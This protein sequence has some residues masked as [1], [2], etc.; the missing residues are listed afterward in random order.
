MVVVHLHRVLVILARVAHSGT[1]CV[2]P[3]T[4]CVFLGWRP[5]RAQVTTHQPL[6]PRS[7]L[8]LRKVGHIGAPSL[9]PAGFQVFRLAERH[10]VPAGFRRKKKKKNSGIE[11]VLSSHLGEMVGRGKDK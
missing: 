7:L 6:S 4:L 8:D 11:F 3:L 2:K 5:A 9:N 1:R 10:L